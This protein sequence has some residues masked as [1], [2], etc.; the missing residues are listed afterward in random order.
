MRFMLSGFS[1]LPGQSGW[2]VFYPDRPCLGNRIFRHPAY[3]SFIIM[4][5]GIALGYSSLLG[6][7]AIPVFL[8]PGLIYRI[9]VEE[10]LLSM[11]FGDRYIQ[12]EK[13]TWRLFPGI[14]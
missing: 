4:G 5:L 11:E 13:S 14:W 8:I 6:L 3:A 12:Y 9:T 7:I 1:D 2:L 10:K